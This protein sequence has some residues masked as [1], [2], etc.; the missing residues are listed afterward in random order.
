MRVPKTREN[1]PLIRH[2]RAVVKPIQR[3]GDPVLRYVIR[4]IL[5]S[6]EQW[7]QTEQGTGKSAQ[8]EDGMHRVRRGRT[9]SLPAGS[10]GRRAEKPPG[11]IAQ[12]SVP[13]EGAWGRVR[14]PRAP[15][16]ILA[17]PT[18]ESGFS[19]A[20][21]SIPQLLTPSAAVAWTRLR[22]ERCRVATPDGYGTIAM[23]PL[24][25][26]GRNQ[27]CCRKKFLLRR[28]I[29]LTAARTRGRLL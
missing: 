11:A 29:L 24:Q 14:P 18:C 26:A 25:S 9:A 15:P 10:P 7:T 5:K 28:R 3:S 20:S 13:S 2:T 6:T 19:T 16:S 1:K 23:E 22:P 8:K 4:R 12:F 21:H 27:V 17:S